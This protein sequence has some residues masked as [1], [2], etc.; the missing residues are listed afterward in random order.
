LENYETDFFLKI[1]RHEILTYWF[2]SLSPFFSIGPFLN[3]EK[4]DSIGEIRKNLKNNTACILQSTPCSYFYRFS[5]TTFSFFFLYRRKIH[6]WRWHIHFLFRIFL[7][8]LEV[9]HPYFLR[10]SGWLIY[11]SGVLY[12]SLN[13]IQNRYSRKNK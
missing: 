6:G 10:Y 5:L 13:L 4:K 3:V 8:S 11:T 12:H 2:F 7:Y 9:I 1:R